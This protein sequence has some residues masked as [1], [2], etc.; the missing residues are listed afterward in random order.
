VFR[1]V[2]FLTLGAT[3]VCDLA[4]AALLDELAL[5]VS[6][7]VLASVLLASRPMLPKRDL[8]TVSRTRDQL[9]MAKSTRPG[10]ESLFGIAPIGFLRA[11]S[12]MEKVH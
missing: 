9:C 2:S 10:V 12:T 6:L 5:F 3:V 11:D 1:P 7:A 8:T 4:L